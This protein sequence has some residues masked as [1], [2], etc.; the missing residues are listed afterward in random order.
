MTELEQIL[1]HIE[2]KDNFLLSGGAG[3]G[4]TY[5]L[6]EVINNVIKKYPSEKVFCMTY[7][8]IAVKEIEERVNHKNLRVATIHD[9]LWDNIKYFQ[10]EIKKS[11]IILANDAN[12]KIKIK[13]NEEPIPDNFFDGLNQVQYK[14]F[15][16]MHEG[17]ISHDE[18]IWLSEYMFKTYKKLCDILKDKYKFIFVDEYQDTHKE[19][20]DILLKHLKISTKENI[21]GF[22]GD[23]MQ[24][25]YE[26]GVD[27]INIYIQDNSLKEVKKLQNRRSPRLVIELANRLRTDSI[28][29]EPST[30]IT[31]P[32]MLNGVVK[33]GI[34]KFIYSDN[35]DLDIVRDYLIQ[36]YNW[37]F[38]DTKNIK[39]LNLT[40]NLI[41]SKAGFENLMKIYDGDQI[42]KFRD[43]IKKYIKDNN[44][45][46]DFTDMTF[47][48]VI[49]VLQNGKTGNELK[50]VKP[51]P[52]MQTFID[53]NS[54]LFEYTKEY[55][56][57]NLLKIYLDKEQFLDDKKQTEN[58][59]KKKGSK[60]DN[61]IKHLFKIQKAISMYQLGKYN[62]F[63]K[64]TD[65]KINCIQDKLDLK[66]KIESLVN[67]GN[68]TIAQIIDEANAY[69]ICIKDDKLNQFIA[70]KVYVFNRVKQVKFSEFQKFFEYLEGKTP[71]T[72]QHKTKGDEFDNVLVVLDNGNWT[73]YNFENLF[74]E[75]STNENVLK[76][77]KKLFYVCCTRAK[78]NL[79]V[80]YHNP[81]AEVIEKA[82]VWFGEE[83]ILELLY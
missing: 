76:R 56:F 18:L 8:N 78:E 12:S 14:E 33:D 7:T 71:F 52:S 28:M 20:V 42:L 22:F 34:I 2:N 5:S 57:M 11:L 3:S 49:E 69:G 16:K 53:T 31:A 67:V 9:F 13:R 64:V 79:V 37:N 38:S 58:E 80:F 10:K 24:S 60:R 19:V 26:N 50:K 15:V 68:K 63:L 27:D 1:Q 41:A 51:T 65:L 39:E 81:S 35:N 73:Q 54:E 40:H 21:I 48:E 74:L 59:E 62:E 47:G 61:L 75:N 36:N 82:K 25:I 23:A 66:Q 44:I 32:N 29:Q 77:T 55:N 43:R 17:I 30:D 70:E 72:T 83:N 6:V 4:K 46:N 45:Q